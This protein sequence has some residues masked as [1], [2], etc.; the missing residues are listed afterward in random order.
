MKRKLK[1]TALFNIAVAICLVTTALLGS[2]PVAAQR[3]VYEFVPASPES[4]TF[5]SKDVETGLI[6]YFDMYVN[7]VRNSTTENTQIQSNK[8]S[9]QSVAPYVPDDAILSRIIIGLDDRQP[10]PSTTT[11]PFSA[12]CC[13][14]VTYPNGQTLPMTGWLFWYDIVITAGH[15]VY[16]SSKGG[17]ATSITVIPGANGSS[18]PYGSAIGIMFASDA[19]WVNNG[20]RDYDWALIQISAGLGRSAGCF[21]LTYSNSSYVDTTVTIAGY[22]YEYEKTREM[23]YMSGNII[24]NTANLLSYTIDTTE[25][26]SGSP[27]YKS[28]NIAIGIHTHGTHNGLFWENRGTR[29]TQALY[30]YFVSFR[31]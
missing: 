23:W 5:I 7:G 12:I 19:A 28:D 14:L 21:G 4:A 11:F 30:N 27:I 16:N 6:S 9:V 22:P 31:V 13:L 2:M 24:S 8:A 26:Q 3:D 15:V 29:I 1:F 10:V 18:A 20:D 17:W 25:G